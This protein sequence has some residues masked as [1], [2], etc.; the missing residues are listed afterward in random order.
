MSHRFP[1]VPELGTALLA[2]VSGALGCV[3]L[4]APATPV[5][6]QSCGV[7]TPG[8]PITAPSPER[9]SVQGRVTEGSHG[10]P[11]S[12]ARVDYRWEDRDGEERRGDTWTDPDGRYWICEVP[13][14]V[15]I[16]L[17]P[18]VGGGPG[19][20]LGTVAS[21]DAAVDLVVPLPSP[22]AP[23]GILG[24][25]REAGT[26]RRV[27]NAEVRI[28]DLELATSTDLQGGFFFSDVEPGS[29]RIQIEHL[30]Y[31]SVVDTVHLV[32][33]R[34]LDV[35]FSLAPEPIRIAGI[36]ATARSQRWFHAR[37]DRM[38]RIQRGHGDYITA[39]EIA[40]RDEPPLHFL[41]QSVAGVRS[42]HVAH[43]WGNTYYPVIRACGVPA[44]YVD[45]ARI[46]IDPANGVGIDDFLSSNIELIEIYKGSST[47]PVGYPPRGGCGT[48]LIWTHTPG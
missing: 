2:A 20:E 9:I 35:R 47:A 30:S 13:R 39:D 40:R 22:D 29:Y 21:A 48:I 44:V 33:G 46:A 41:L 4:S 19:E 1:C 45:G 16:V 24:R 17:S 34:P 10:V 23:S 27:G 12:G 31:G 7:S 15:E 28:P 14:G 18:E 3:L 38:R 26:D 32:A 5:A 25:V 37:A 42:D 43:P 36:E 6:A 8:I 11:V